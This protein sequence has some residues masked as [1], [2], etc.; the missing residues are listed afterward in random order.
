MINHFPH[1]TFSAVGILAL[2]AIAATLGLAGCASTA[3]PPTS[4]TTAPTA[5]GATPPPTNGSNVG[6]CMTAQLS[7]IRAPGSGA[8]MGGQQ[9]NKIVLTNTSTTA[10]TLQGWPG[11]SLVSGAAGQQIGAPASFRRDTAHPTVTLKPGGSADAAFS[12]RTVVKSDTQTGSCTTPTAV[13]GLRVY[14]PSQTK[15]LFIPA[16]Y[17]V[18]PSTT[19]GPEFAVSAFL[20]A[21]P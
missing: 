17:V 7:G 15:A 4:T 13:G 6:P 16:P 10:C 11:T 21:Q 3:T 9:D 14:P 19:S 5:V 1:T 2:G 18:C 12:L 8:G 20:P